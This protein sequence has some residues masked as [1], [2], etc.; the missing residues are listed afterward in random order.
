[1][2]GGGWANNK[3]WGGVNRKRKES[4]CNTLI[5]GFHYELMAVIFGECY[6]DLASCST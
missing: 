1:V 5:N 3:N 2:G 6:L 4:V